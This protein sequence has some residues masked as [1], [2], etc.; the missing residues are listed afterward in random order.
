M[1]QLVYYGTNYAPEIMTSVMDMSSNG[2][3][4]AVKNS[5]SANNDDGDDESG[6]C[7]C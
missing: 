2:N 4:D 1:G 7:A 5:D 6:D 3:M